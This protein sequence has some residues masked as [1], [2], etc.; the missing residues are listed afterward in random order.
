MARI[1]PLVAQTR[2]YLVQT[3]SEAKAI[4]ESWLHEIELSQMITLGLPEVDD[5]YHV[6]RVP[7]C[8]KI[9]D[10]RVG[11]TVIDAYTTAILHEKTTKPAMLESRLLQKDEVKANRRVPTQAYPISTLRNTIG[12][13]DN[14]ALLDEMPADSVDL[15]FTSPP[16]FNAR[17]EYSDYE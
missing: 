10:E 11:E 12:L 9:N 3:V 4:T 8:N 1:K 7:L 5:R 15:I 17:P 6:W 16:Y 14:V 2:R 13:G